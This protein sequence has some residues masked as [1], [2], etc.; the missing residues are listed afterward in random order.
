MHG[1]RHK[2]HNKRAQSHRARAQAKET[3]AP[4]ED[5]SHDAPL[6]AAVVADHVAVSRGAPRGQHRRLLKA[7]DFI[8]IM[9]M[10]RASSA[11]RLSIDNLI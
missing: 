6:V 5:V 10:S 9:I 7:R 2:H 3:V 1:Q 11:A 4:A 8:L